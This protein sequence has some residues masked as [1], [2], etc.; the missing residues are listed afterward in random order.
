MLT[1]KAADESRKNAEGR[2]GRLAGELESAVG[3]M[4]EFAAEASYQPRAP[5][6][7]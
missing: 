2:L 3:E 7:D 6:A 4:L 1:R 5:A